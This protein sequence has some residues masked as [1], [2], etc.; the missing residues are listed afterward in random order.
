MRPALLACISCAVA[1]VAAGCGGSSSGLVPR[2]D[3]GA[4]AVAI[5]SLGCGACHAIDGIEGADGRV[6][7]SLHDLED[8]LYIA[9]RLPNTPQNLIRWITSPQAVDPGNLMPD[10]GVTAA[11]AR[12]IAA[13]LTTH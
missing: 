5:R 1:T 7:P 9:G 12:D 6:G 2:G 11:E 10:L 8:R 13:Y 4:G 3:A